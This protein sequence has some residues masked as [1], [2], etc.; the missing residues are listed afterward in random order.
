M[1]LFF[2]VYLYSI[3]RKDNMNTIKLDVEEEQSNNKSD[4]KDMKYW[5]QLLQTQ[6]KNDISKVINYHGI[7]N[8]V[9]LADYE[10][11]TH[12]TNELTNLI[13]TINKYDKRHG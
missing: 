2:F 11:A 1:L 9:G 5:T 12:L 10:I 4:L 8:F 13:N 7:E 6:V 3:E